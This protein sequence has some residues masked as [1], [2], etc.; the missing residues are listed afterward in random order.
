MATI[1]KRGDLQWKVKVRRMGFPLQ[2]RSFDAK[3]E[4]EAWAR[5]LDGK[6]WC[7]SLYCDFSDYPGR[8]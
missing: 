6:N 5:L 1:T 4:S 8:Q 7:L 2:S 3:A